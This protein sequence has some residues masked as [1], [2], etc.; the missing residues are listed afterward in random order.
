MNITESISVCPSRHNRYANDLGKPIMITEPSL[1]GLEHGISSLNFTFETKKETKKLPI[2]T[3]YPIYF[4]NEVVFK[5]FHNLFFSNHNAINQ[6][7]SL[8]YSYPPQECSP[9]IHTYIHTKSQS[10]IPTLKFQFY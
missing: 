2:L 1:R 8:L 3:F 6:T 9:N 10:T 4:F 5:K 7:K